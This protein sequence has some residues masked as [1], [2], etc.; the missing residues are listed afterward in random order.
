VGGASVFDPFLRSY[1][2]KFA[3]K[4]VTSE[5][6]RSFFLDHFKDVEAVKQVGEQCW[7]ISGL[8]V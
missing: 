8:R 6:F 4:T 1:L 5:E 3:Y 7:T 2:T